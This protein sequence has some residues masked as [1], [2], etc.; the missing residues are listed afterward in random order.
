MTV[1]GLDPGLTAAAAL[2]DGQRVLWVG[3]LPV[4][5]IRSGQRL[6]AELDLAGLRALLTRQPIDH[7]I[8]EQQSARPGQGVAGMFRLGLTLGQIIGLVA[9][10]RLRHSLVQPKAWQKEA[11]CGPSPDAA[12]QRAGQLYPESSDRLTLTK[13]AGRADAIL[14]AHYGHRHHHAPNETRP[15][16][17]AH[18]VAALE[19]AAVSGD[20]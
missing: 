10:L 17:E 5:Q 11:G 1:L 20:A 14:I 18:P 9:G 15:A 19:A 13:H 8:I 16:A 12:R 7:V 6:R 2:L 4:H 3:D